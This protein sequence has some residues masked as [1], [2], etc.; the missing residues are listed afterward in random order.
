MC[1]DPAVFAV[2]RERDRP[3]GDATF[4]KYPAAPK[5]ANEIPKILQN[6]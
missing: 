6:L 5:I 1:H 4:K 3:A 2:N